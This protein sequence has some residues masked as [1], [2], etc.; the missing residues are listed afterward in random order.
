MCIERFSVIHIS[1]NKIISN[2]SCCFVCTKYSRSVYFFGSVCVL[3]NKLN[4]VIYSKVNRASVLI[5]NNRGN[6]PDLSFFY[7][8]CCHRFI[9]LVVLRLLLLC[10]QLQGLFL[11]QLNKPLKRLCL[12]TFYL[13]IQ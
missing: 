11:Y 1:C 2:L 10:P 9:G 7:I 5:F 6:T 4:I 3:H 8:N 12:Y 13:A